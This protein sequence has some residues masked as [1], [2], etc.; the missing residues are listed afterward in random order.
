MI[1]LETLLAASDALADV[2]WRGLAAKVETL[3]AAFDALADVP[4]RGLAA[5]ARHDAVTGREPETV[6]SEALEGI[7]RYWFVA[8]ADPD[9]TVTAIADILDAMRLWKGKRP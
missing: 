5:K 3:L 6:A 1:P 8:T 4:W 7:A 2:P 9:E